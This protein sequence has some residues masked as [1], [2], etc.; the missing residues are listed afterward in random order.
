MK[1]YWLSKMAENFCE[2]SSLSIRLT[3]V[4]KFA[5]FNP[6]IYGIP[7]VKLKIISI[8]EQNAYPYRNHVMF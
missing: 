6:K 5:A 3:S 4:N 7:R 1:A 8:M 2:R